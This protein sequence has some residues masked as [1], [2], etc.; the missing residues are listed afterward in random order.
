MKRTKAQLGKLRK[1]S[2]KR[3]GVKVGQNLV[4]AVV[5]L[6]TRA[7][8]KKEGARLAEEGATLVRLEE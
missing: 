3:K 2:A 4:T 8:K 6:N 5:A 1:M 7:A